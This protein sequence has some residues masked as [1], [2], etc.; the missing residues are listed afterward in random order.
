MARRQKSPAP[1]A[2]GSAPAQPA[3]PAKPKKR[4][5]LTIYNEAL[6]TRIY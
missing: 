6:W 4:P 1:T 2:P 5:W 3:E